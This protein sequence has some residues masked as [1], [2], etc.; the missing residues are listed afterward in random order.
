MTPKRK[1]IS[2]Q[3]EAFQTLQSKRPRRLST[4]SAFDSQ[5]VAHLICL[6]QSSHDKGS[7]TI[8]STCPSDWIFFRTSCVPGFSTCNRSQL[9]EMVMNSRTRC[10]VYVK[11]RHSSYVILGPVVSQVHFKIHVFVRCPFE[12]LVCWRYS[13]QYSIGIGCC[14]TR[15]PS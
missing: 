14:L 1:L 10:L 6:S 8:S 15:L 5:R 3:D 4:L 11:K 12:N 9:C 2:S 13:M 7:Y